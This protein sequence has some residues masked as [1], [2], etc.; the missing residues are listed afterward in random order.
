M[1]STAD[2]KGSNRSIASWES[3]LWAIQRKNS[4]DASRPEST[5]LQFMPIEAFVPIRLPLVGNWDENQLHPDPSI[6]P[7]VNISPYVICDIHQWK[8]SFFITFGFELPLITIRKNCD[9]CPNAP[10]IEL[11]SN[12]SIYGKRIRLHLS[13][14]QTWFCCKLI[15]SRRVPWIVGVPSGVSGGSEKQ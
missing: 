10:S 2:W 15:S 13:N 12:D 14:L 9:S 6:L 5:L 1:A 8:Y 11:E 7:V 4:F 3:I